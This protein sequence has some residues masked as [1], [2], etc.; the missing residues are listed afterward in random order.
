MTL[1]FEEEGDLQLPLETKVLAE[2]VIEAALDYE[3]CPYEATVSL[4]LTMNNEIQEMNRNFREIDRATDVLSFPMIAYEEAGTFDF[5]EED[6]SAFDPESG[7]LVLGDIVISK[8]RVI[9]QAEEYGHS[10]RREYAFLIAH[11]MLHLMGYDHMEE[12]E[13]AVMEQKQR[14]ILEQLGITR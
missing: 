9:A 7:E 8:E 4:L 13:R 6:D 3:G 12:E 14:D 2:E 5:L 11:S 10:I 1:L